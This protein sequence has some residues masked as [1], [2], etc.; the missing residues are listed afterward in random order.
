MIS[1]PHPQG[2]ISATIPRLQFIARN[3][4][5]SE[6]TPLEGAPPSEYS[7]SWIGET[8]THSLRLTF[9]R[10]AVAAIFSAPE[11][12]FLIVAENTQELKIEAFPADDSSANNVVGTAVG[13][14]K[15]HPFNA[16]AEQLR[17]ASGPNDI[18]MLVLYTEEARVAA[19]DPVGQCATPQDNDQILAIINAAIADANTA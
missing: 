17:E 5:G 3:G 18:D 10:G 9:H 15:L 7:Y 1:I 12:R 8:D 11:G 4:Y 6:G 14:A 19:G 16:N 13:T 2:T